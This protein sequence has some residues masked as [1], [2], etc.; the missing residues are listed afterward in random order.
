MLMRIRGG[1]RGGD[2]NLQPDFDRRF[3]RHDASA[4]HSIRC[5]RAAGGIERARKGSYLDNANLLFFLSQYFTYSR[6]EKSAGEMRGSA[7]A[8]RR[9]VDP[10]L[11]TFLKCVFSSNLALPRSLSCRSSHRRIVTALLAISAVLMLL[12]LHNRQISPAKSS[13]VNRVPDALQQAG[14]AIDTARTLAEDSRSDLEGG[15]VFEAEIEGEDGA[16]STDEEPKADPTDDDDTFDLTATHSTAVRPNY[17]LPFL[18]F[19]CP[20]TPS[21]RA[22]SSTLSDR[23]TT[24][25]EE[26]IPGQDALLLAPLVARSVQFRG[27]GSE[28][29]RVLRRAVKS[30]LYGSERKSGRT[31]MEQGAE[32]DEKTFRILVLGGSG[33]F[34]FVL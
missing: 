20:A 29:K 22:V 5:E 12:A 1:G 4:V 11:A 18:P 34:S 14:V 19:S 3:P 6:S 30:S 7:S 9:R 26:P 27:T 15:N 10:R 13:S 31:G 8:S 2:D 25:W 17:I 32:E 23:R 33:E 21:T 28:V 16:H 24:R